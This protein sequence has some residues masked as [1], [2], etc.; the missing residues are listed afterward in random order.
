MAGAIST[1]ILGVHMENVD[2]ALNAL[3]ADSNI[4]WDVYVQAL[5]D[6]IHRCQTAAHAVRLEHAPDEFALFA[7]ELAAW[8]DSKPETTELHRSGIAYHRKLRQWRESGDLNPA[9]QETVETLLNRVVI[10]VFGFDPAPRQ[11]RTVKH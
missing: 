8:L 5:E 1:K 11:D 4:P 7:L 6:I 3:A 2:E 9:Q 10:Q